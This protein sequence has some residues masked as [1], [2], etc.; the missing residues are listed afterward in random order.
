MQSDDSRLVEKFDLRNVWKNETLDFT[1]WLVEEEHLQALS[2]A[3]GVELQLE[4]Q[5]QFV[6]MYRPDLICRNGLTGKY[7][8]IENQLE[9]TDARHLGQLLTY[10][11][12]LDAD[13]VVWIAEKFTAEHHATFHWLNKNTPAGIHFFG[14]AIE[15][16]RTSGEEFVPRFNVVCRPDEEDTPFE[17]IRLRS[18]TELSVTQ[19]L[20]VEYWS[21]FRNLMYRRHSSIKPA[22][23]QPRSWIKFDTGHLS[24]IKL[25]IERRRQRLIVQLVPH[26]FYRLFPLREKE[27]RFAF[28]WR[29][30]QTIEINIG[31]GLEWH[32][33]TEKAPYHIDLCL[34]SRDILNRNDWINQHEWLYEKLALFYRVF[35]G[36]KPV[37]LNCSP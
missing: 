26:P 16:W 7:V 15:V 18:V 25:A 19:Q 11:A 29:D 24:Y 14:V 33:P 9:T 6:G 37:V 35:G 3:I 4:A 8:I 20:Y 31:A 5:E 13:T 17:V 2:Q 1:P 21:E 12:S 30:K 22:K 34:Y 10:L 28:L 36:K 23:P 27:L 32:K